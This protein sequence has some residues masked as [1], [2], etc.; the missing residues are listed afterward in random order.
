[1]KK[2]ILM[3]FLGLIFGSLAANAQ[4]EK[5]VGEWDLVIYGTPNG[6]AKMQLSLLREEGKL[7]GRLK[8]ADASELINIT[9]IDEADDSITL[10]FSAQGYDVNVMLKNEDENNMKGSLMDMFDVTAKRILKA[11]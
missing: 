2:S 11:E 5:Y 8:P 6:D 9:Q 4:T 7:M 10:Y 3:L 1:M